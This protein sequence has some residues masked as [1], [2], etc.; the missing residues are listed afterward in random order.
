[1]SSQTLEALLDGQWRE[2]IKI[3]ANYTPTLLHFHDI[4]Y[5]MEFWFP[6]IQFRIMKNG[7]VISAKHKHVT[8]VKCRQ[9]KYMPVDRNQCW[10]CI[11]S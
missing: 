4:G 2:I 7:V 1:M 8:C 11:S 5:Y 9:Q 10:S 3:D 6:P